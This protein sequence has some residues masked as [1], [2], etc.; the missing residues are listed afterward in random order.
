MDDYERKLSPFG[1]FVHRTELRIRRY[2]LRAKLAEAMARAVA[3][4]AKLARKGRS[5]RPG[6]AGPQPNR[7]HARVD[8]SGPETAVG[9]NAATS[10]RGQ[11]HTPGKR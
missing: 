3:V 8:V 5:R 2:E 10:K 7:A 1:K 4:R 9:A 6:R 11:Y